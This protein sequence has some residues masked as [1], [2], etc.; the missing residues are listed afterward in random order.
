[1]DP[2][3][4]A[5][6]L[7]TIGGSTIPLGALLARWERIRPNWLETEFRHAVIA[8]GGG[9]LLAAVA[10]VLVPQGIRFLS[11]EQVLLAFAIGGL[12]FFLLDRAIAASGRAASQLIAMLLDFVPEAIA[13]GAV[14]ATEGSVGLLFAILIAVQNLP[15]GFNAYREIMARGAH[16][17]KRVLWWFCGLVLL[18]PLAAYMG[19]SLIAGEPQWLG[20]IMLF[21]S[22]GILYLT[23]QDVAPQSHM[24]RHWGPSLGAVAGFGL[25]L[26]AKMLLP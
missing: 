26:I 12:T 13:L 22:A 5:L 23:F 2:L 18:G 19:F 7:A 25:A 11:A 17:A 6:L 14:L 9:V 16:P 15:E 8:F 20:A 24:R 1:M 3:Y 21:A 10:L 4:Y